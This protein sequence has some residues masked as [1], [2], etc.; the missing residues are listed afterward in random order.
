[1]NFDW[2]TDKN[3]FNILKHGIDFHDTVEI[4]IHPMVIKE[5]TRKNYGE[6]RWISIGRLKDITVVVVFTVRI[7]TIRIISAR[8]ANLKER[9]KYYEKFG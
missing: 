1:M 2:D 4:F 3:Q 5:D 9:K 6:R 7:N 8:K